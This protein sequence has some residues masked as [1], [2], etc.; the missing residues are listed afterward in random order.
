MTVRVLLVDDHPIFRLGLRS[1]LIKDGIQVVGEAENLRDARRLLHELS[2]DVIVLDLMLGNGSGL[3]LL[4]ELAQLAPQA[5]ALVL[6]MMDEELYAERVLQQGAKGYLMKSEDPKRLVAAVR[7]VATGEVQV[8]DQLTRRLLRRV[9]QGESFASDPI[10]SLT[11]RELEV[12]QLIG[13]GHTTKQ[14]ADALSLSPKTVE[15]HQAKIK[16]KLGLRTTN[17]LVRHAVTWIQ[18]VAG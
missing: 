13:Q 11:T 12:F 9:V 2:P 17:Q 18:R 3:E 7:G 16:R 8:S 1:L 10:D 6:S 15:T 14:V 5:S 4:E